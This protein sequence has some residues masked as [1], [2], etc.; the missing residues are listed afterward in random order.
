MKIQ[1]PAVVR[2]LDPQHAGLSRQHHL[3]R[4]RARLTRRLTHLR[5][6]DT[7]TQRVRQQVGENLAQRV[8]H[9]LIELAA[10]PR[11]LKARLLAEVL[12]QA[13]HL[14]RPGREQPTGINRLQRG[15]DA[16]HGSQITLCNGAA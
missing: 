10:L 1:A 16:G 2:H 11:Q 7:V 13:R 6:L 14:R 9:R 3:E 8:K 12:R 5:Q 4:A 15:H